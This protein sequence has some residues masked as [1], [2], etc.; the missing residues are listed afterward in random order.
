MILLALG[1]SALVAAAA[2]PIVSGL[3]PA[4]GRW[5][6]AGAVPLAAGMAWILDW[7]AS[8][9]VTV[10]VPFAIGLAVVAAV[11]AVQTVLDLATHRLPR[12]L[13]YAGLAA[14]LVV[15]PFSST[16]VVDRWPG[17]L[18]GLVLMMAIIVLLLVIT[19]GSL[20]MGD[21][22]LAPLLGALVGFFSPALLAI[23]WLVTA[24]TGGVVVALGLVTR[25][26]DRSQHI[27]YGPFMI[28]GA[29]VASVVAA[30]SVH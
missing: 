25:R 29:F 8:R 27:P 5:R 2:L 15:L 3:A 16:S 13:S 30:M 17:V 22:H 10:T 6:A 12:Q 18:V 14:F 20:G 28:L 4:L 23:A 1:L 24:V 26:L 11:L 9:F 21:V 19:R 7:S